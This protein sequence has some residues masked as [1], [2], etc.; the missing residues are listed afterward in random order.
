MCK[1][2]RRLIKTMAYTSIARGI[3]IVLSGYGIN[4]DKWVIYMLN[5]VISTPISSDASA[6]ILSGLLGL[7]AMF[8]AEK[9]YPFK[10]SDRMPSEHHPHIVKTLSKCHRILINE[11]N[12][13]VHNKDLANNYFAEIDNEFKDLLSIPEILNDSELIKL[14]RNAENRMKEILGMAISVSFDS[15]KLERAYKFQNSDIMSHGHYKKDVKAIIEQFMEEKDAIYEYFDNSLIGK[16]RKWIK[17]NAH[18]KKLK[19]LAS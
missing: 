5:T 9:Y 16:I 13:I 2:I 6:W 15:D 4:P 14:I 3:L 7:I 11:L 1:A 12:D 19:K 8:L 17:R 10:K 18:L